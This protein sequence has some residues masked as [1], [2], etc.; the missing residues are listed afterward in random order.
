MAKRVKARKTIGQKK[1]TAESRKKGSSA[2][3]K[4]LGEEQ[5]THLDRLLL[6]RE[7]IELFHCQAGEAYA[8]VS[9]DGHSENWSLK[10][11]KFRQWLVKH[12]FDRYKTPPR[13]QSVSEALSFM[14]AWASFDG[15]RHHVDVRLIAVD[16]SLYVDLGDAEW[17]AV[18]IRPG[19]WKVVRRP[20]V[21]FRRGPALRSL[22]RPEPSDNLDALRRFVNCGDD[23]DTWRLLIA[24]MVM[25]F[26]PRG[27]YPVLVL[28]GQQG[29]SKSTTARVIRALTDPASPSQR[30]SPRDEKDLMIAAVMNRVVAFD[31]LSG[32]RAEM[33]DQLSRLAT[34]GGV[35]TR[36]LYTNAD[37]FLF[38]ATRPILLNGIDATATRGDLADRSLV[39]SLPPIPPELRR[40][41]ASFWEAFT[42]EAP[43]IFGALLSTVAQVLRLAPRVHL[44]SM[45]RM[46]DFARWGVA[47]E[48]A[49]GW[50][51]DS[52]LV[53]YEQNRL[54]G[55]RTVVEA[56]TVALAVRELM[57]GDADFDGSATRLL[58]RL[59]SV[60]SLDNQDRYWPKTPN[61]L[62]VRL[63]R[64]APALLAFG[65]RV[66]VGR[67][68]T[69]RR[70]TL[71]R[72]PQRVVNVVRDRARPGKEQ[73][74]STTEVKKDVRGTRGLRR[75][76]RWHIG[77]LTKRTP[78]GRDA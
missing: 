75:P 29:A 22:P 37:E 45:P 46:A 8:T 40:D 12:Y 14:N 32:I 18:R 3:K 10:S 47:T 30:S 9:V 69:G 72:V 71:G 35:G 27:P 15:E 58:E 53:A 20:H 57:K 23:E 24:W 50:P 49:L 61:A 63:R 38:E 28:Q 39:L 13:S 74:R 59:R 54:A 5:E 25:C 70:I 56:D 44:P 26:H 42:A 77:S 36:Q 48:R 55:A 41:E 34:G 76:T 21:K 19:E 2:E 1:G 33:S 17:A 4:T 16:G 51:K 43:A 73:P 52:F 60:A 68:G 67:D 64:L 65:I 66:S 62:G 7:E 11:P 78:R 6:F 31:N